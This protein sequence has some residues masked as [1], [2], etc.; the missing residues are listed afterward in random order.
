MDELIAFVKA[1]LGE[2]EAAANEV[3]RPRGC[4]CVDRDGGFDPDPIW[5]GC[6][7]PARVL[8][9]VAAK[10]A[11]LAAYIKIEAGGIRDSGWIAFRSTLATLA[12]VW[13]DH[14]DYRQEWAPLTPAA[15]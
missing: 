7:Y 6:D 5:C 4:G 2:D 9:E 14:P 8:R 11:V 15:P 13:N 12:A 3:H 1:R 10:R